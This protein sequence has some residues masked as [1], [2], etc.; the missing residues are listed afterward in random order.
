[1]GSSLLMIKKKR[2]WDDWS[3]K[4]SFILIKKTGVVSILPYEV[5]RENPSD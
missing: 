3:H 4:C 5:A 1:V 2:E